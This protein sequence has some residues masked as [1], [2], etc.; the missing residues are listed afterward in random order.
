MILRRPR[1]LSSR[2]R[3][4]SLDGLR[5][6]ADRDRAIRTYNQESFHD[7]FREDLLRAQSH[8]LLLS[9]FMAIKRATYYYAYLEDAI[10]RNCR[11]VVCSKPEHEVT[12][13]LRDDHSRIVAALE[14]IGAQFRSRPGMH[15]KVAIV[16][17]DIL[18]S[19]SLNILSHNS[20]T[21]LM[22]R[23]EVAE[24]V[25]EVIEELSLQSFVEFA[26]DSDRE[27]GVGPGLPRHLPEGDLRACAECGRPMVFFDDSSMWICSGAPGCSGFDLQD[28][29]P[30]P[31]LHGASRVAEGREERG[32]DS[33][34]LPGFQCPDC[35][36]GVQVHKGLRP[37]VGCSSRG[38]GFR[39]DPQLSKWLLKA[40]RRTRA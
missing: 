11:V 12:G 9:P 17:D 10:R 18:W 3:G 15:E 5:M 40:L 8:V 35:G 13:D 39:I 36:A 14:Q 22:H 23:M 24:V 27:E 30:P 6:R 26:S 19:G 25:V 34:L 32:R 2:P 31:A 20:T 21:E 37:R 4:D 28:E 38:C 7:A 16:D 33:D 29:Q 1:A